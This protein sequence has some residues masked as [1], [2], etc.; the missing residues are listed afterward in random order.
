[1]VVKGRELAEKVLPTATP[2]RWVPKSKASSVPTTG[3]GIADCGLSVV[4]TRLSSAL[5]SRSSIL[6]PAFSGMPDILY[7][8]R[9]IHTE[10]CH[11]RCQPFFSRQFKQ[12]VLGRGYGQ[13]DVFVDFMLQLALL[14]ARIAQGH[15]TRFPPPSF[16]FT[17]R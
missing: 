3:L 1:M 8:H 12:N 17:Q 9:I 15:P 6:D 13:P 4:T 10:Q 7:Q 11:R 16:F 14:P 2:M 5:D